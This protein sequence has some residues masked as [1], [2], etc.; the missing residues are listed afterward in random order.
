MRFLKPLSPLEIPEKPTEG[1]PDR[2]EPYMGIYKPTG[3]GPF[4]A[5]VLQHT[6]GGVQEHIGD[7]TKQFHGAG[8]VVL[9]LDSLTQRNV[10]NN[11][12]IPVPV[13]TLN[14]TLDAYQA[15]EH[16]V[17]QPY[18]DKNRIGMLGLSWGGMNALLVARKDI[19]EAL[20]RSSK[21]LRFRAVAS[22]YPHCFMPQLRTPR[23]PLDIEYLSVDATD[24]PL[25][26]LMGEQDEET[27]PKFCLPRLEALKA[28]GAKVAWHVFPQTTHA[29]DN[30]LA[31][32]RVRRT[33][34]GGSHRYE[35]NA[36]AT[37]ESYKRV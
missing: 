34:F 25:L 13:P 14:G 6:C 16:L 2:S 22:V 9:V 15:L 29:W 37:Q 10:S 4:P 36:A 31:S 20:P 35:F 21:E 12:T 27:P 1:P 32:G 8:Y 19:A 26:V 18:V 11:C 17:K 3:P 33:V 5:V 28:K 7:W 23:G 24:R 30:R